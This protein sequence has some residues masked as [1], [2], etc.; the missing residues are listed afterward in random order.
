MLKCPEAREKQKSRSGNKQPQ[1]G[2]DTTMEQK[3]A[4]EVDL[5]FMS[6]PVPSI[7]INST[8]FDSKR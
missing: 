4:H 3:G 2:V 1:F 7:P 5:R 6:S 8:R